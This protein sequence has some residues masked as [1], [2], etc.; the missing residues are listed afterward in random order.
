MATLLSRLE[1]VKGWANPYVTSV[2]KAGPVGTA[3]V[4][5]AGTVDLTTAA[6]TPRGAQGAA[7]LGGP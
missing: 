3:I 1:T 7:A 6:L 4:Q 5:F 2:S